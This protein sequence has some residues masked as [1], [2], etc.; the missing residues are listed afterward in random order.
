[1]RFA[2][3]EK[4]ESLITDAEADIAVRPGATAA[5]RNSGSVSLNGPGSSKKGCTRRPDGEFEGFAK[6]PLMKKAHE[7]QTHALSNRPATGG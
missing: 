6:N 4:G 7:D 2:L 3:D 5:P 1:M